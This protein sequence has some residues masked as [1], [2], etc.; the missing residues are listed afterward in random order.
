MGRS[1]LCGS[2]SRPN[3]PCACC[4][5]ATAVL[6]RLSS[7][8]PTRWQRSS[9]TSSRH[10]FCDSKQ[11]FRA[12]S[13]W[14]CCCR[15]SMTCHTLPSGAVTPS[16]SHVA[17]AAAVT[18]T[19]G[20]ATAGTAGVNT[21]TGARFLCSGSPDRPSAAARSVH[22][23][24]A[25]LASGGSLH[26]SRSPAATSPIWL[27]SCSTR[28]STVSCNSRCRTAISV[29]ADSGPLACVRCSPA[30]GRHADCA[31]GIGDATAGRGDRALVLD[32]G[33]GDIVLVRRAGAGENVLV[34]G[35]T[36]C[37]TPRGRT[38]TRGLCGCS[39]AAGD[40]ALA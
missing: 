3:W 40:A 38:A 21:H 10:R 12:S 18:Q 17:A 13:C 2:R 6:L 35:S 25:C 14:F 19:S 36:W 7:K 16:G 29:S 26:H 37:A 20:G 33:K 30:F 5:A 28:R 15:L 39:R 24:T 34:R 9:M 22:C 31:G 11:A 1:C 4:T 32:A 8:L 23:S 27:E